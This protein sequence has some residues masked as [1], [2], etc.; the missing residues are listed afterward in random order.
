MQERWDIVWSQMRG[1]S[2]RFP[3]AISGALALA[4]FAAAEA[5]QEDGVWKLRDV[6]LD[7]DSYGQALE[8][9]GT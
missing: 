9:I 1:H 8:Q 3:S 2:A 4:V 5:V 7:G 6:I